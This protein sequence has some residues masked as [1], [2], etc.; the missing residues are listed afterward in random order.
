MSDRTP[1]PGMQNPEEWRQDLNP[2]AHAGQNRGH[3][4]EP[5][6]GRRTLYDEKELHRRFAGWND[7]DLKEVPLVPAGERL[8][9][10]A[11]YI[12]LTS[13]SPE[14]FTARGDMG[15]EDGRCYVAKGSVDYK[16]WNRLLGVQQPERLNTGRS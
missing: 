16:R 11:T 10:G 1:N 7:E 4:G 6:A 2:A 12:D 13:A 3:D 15:V 8:Q 5:Q 9:Q 14:E